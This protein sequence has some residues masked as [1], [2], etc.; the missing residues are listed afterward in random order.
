MWSM[1]ALRSSSAFDGERFLTDGA[2]VLYDGEV[3][4]GVEPAA[5]DVPAD[6]GVTTYDGT[7]MPG[8]IDCHTHLV[9]D[10]TMG[11]LEAAGAAD[12]ATLDRLI[13]E[14]LALQL[15]GGVTTVRDLGDKAF[16]SVVARDRADPGVPRIVAAGPPLTTVGG[17]CHYW[18]GEVAGPDSA[19]EAVAEHA[20]RG[21]DLI[22][23]MA[24][25]GAMTPG[26]DPLG[27]Q[28][29]DELAAIVDEAHRRG[30]RVVAHAHSQAGA[31]LALRSGVDG[32]EHFTSLSQ[33]GS[34]TPED[35]LAAVAEAG[36]TVDPTCGWDLSQFP[37]LELLPEN[38]RATMERLGITPEINRANRAVQ[39]RRLRE[40]GVRV[41]S[42]MDSGV[43]GVKAHG[44]VWRN[45]LELVDAGWPVDE[46]LAT[47]TS[48]AAGDCG[49]QA[50]RLRAGLS[51]D[52]LVLDGDVRS[53]PTALS[54]P[55]EVVVR[56]TT[57]TKWRK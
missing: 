44:N 51:A 5:Y 8:L 39:V 30:L 11:G 16:R 43:S 24:S 29:D 49:V 22:K 21:V 34:T 47:A 57:P 20:E 14:S 46:S 52:L 37:P 26:T 45:V 55:L 1:H 28:L 19:R 17:H 53:D 38:I 23:V 4:V 48:V 3:I 31:W 12:E 32:L 6:C 56:G 25:G 54:R 7:L 40:L 33:D 42:G 2:T 15:A 13:G 50:G 35:L 10:S 27:T 36:V 41:V 18:G 9:G